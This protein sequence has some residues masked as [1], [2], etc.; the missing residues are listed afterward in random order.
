MPLSV[1]AHADD[2]SGCETRLMLEPVGAPSRLIHVTARSVIGMTVVS[3]AVAGCATHQAKADVPLGP[4]PP[5]RVVGLPAAKAVDRLAARGLK[6]ADVTGRW[7]QQ[8]RGVILA[9]HSTRSG[10]DDPVVHLVA[11]M[12]PRK[13]ALAVVTL[14]G[15][16]TCDLGPNP[17]GADCRG[18]P[19]I[20]WT[21]HS[22]RH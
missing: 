3:I 6:V 21:R 13:Q 22:H 10:Y 11:S 17:A 18:G 12:G 1:L 20:L 8:R 14:P 19:V 9:Q 16:A 2:R 4:G 7:G 5:P 15:V